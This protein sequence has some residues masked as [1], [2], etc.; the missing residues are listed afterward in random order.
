M[1]VLSVPAFLFG[2]GIELGAGARYMSAQQREDVF[3]IS[4][5]GHLDDEYSPRLQHAARFSE[6]AEHIENMLQYH[7][8][9]YDPEIPVREWQRGNIHIDDMKFAAG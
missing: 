9:G 8:A 3:D 5:V 4:G 2:K 7:D 6:Q 1:Q